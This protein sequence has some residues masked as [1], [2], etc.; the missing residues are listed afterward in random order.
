MKQTD[1]NQTEFLLDVFERFGKN[2]A[3][4][5]IDFV[6]KN[7]AKPE[8]VNRESQTKAPS[9][10]LAQVTDAKEVL[11]FAKNGFYDLLDF[12]KKV[13]T[14]YIR[15]SLEES[16]EGKELEQ[17]ENYSAGLLAIVDVKRRLTGEKQVSKFQS[18][19][20]EA[21]DLGLPSGLL[22]ANKNV[23]ADAPEEPGMYFNFDEASELEFED[24]W[25]VP[26]S[27]AFQEL[28]DNCEHEFV[29]VNGIA[30]MKFTSK[31]NGNSVFFPCSGSGLG[32]TWYN[33]GS[34]GYYWSGSLYSATDGRDLNLYS[35]GVN[36]QNNN[37]RFYG[38]AV[39]AV[40]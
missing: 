36:P 24:G 11:D 5:A 9:P 40:Q 20:F 22:W 37:N 21:V 19:P 13:N 14:L 15:T 10:M 33:R 12:A 4:A 29:Q 31:I 28:D 3:Q 18:E 23:G 25:K 26:E 1:I 2:E 39:R 27:E 6:R 30:G 34:R 38:F 16:L 8:P 35:G 7:S 17:L 32:T